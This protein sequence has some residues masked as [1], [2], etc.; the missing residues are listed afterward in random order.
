MATIL[1]ANTDVYSPGE[2]TN[3]FYKW[4]PLALYRYGKMKRAAR[5]QGRHFLVEKTPRHVRRIDKIRRLVPGAKFVIAVRDGRDVVASLTKR[6]GD[7]RHSVDRWISD[8]A[9]ALAQLGRPDVTMYKYEDLVED[10]SATVERICNFLGLR[11]DPSM[12]DYHQKPRH[13]FSGAAAVKEPNHIALRNQQ[14]AQPIYDGRGRWRSELGEAELNE[15]TTGR[16]REIMEAFG[17]LQS[18]QT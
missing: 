15:L 8:N 6:L 16:G 5:A 1:S 17:Y 12:L 2:E 13:W 4:A 3:V 11:F 14:I 9:D 7:P 10:P 18:E